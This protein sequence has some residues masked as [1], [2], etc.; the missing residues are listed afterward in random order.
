MQLHKKSHRCGNN[1][2]S[3]PSLH[4]QCVPSIDAENE[5][6]FGWCY[7]RKHLNNSAITGDWGYC[8]ESCQISGYIDK[9]INNLAK[10]EYNDL[11]TEDIFMLSFQTSGHC[12]TYN[13]PTKS[14]AGNHEG[15]YAHL[16]I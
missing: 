9:Y 4:D 11:W 2:T 16:G 15:F 13:P 10:Q 1:K 6:K 3:I 12:H 7:T 5:Y 8:N 14:Y